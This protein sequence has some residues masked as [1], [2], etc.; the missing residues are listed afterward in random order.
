MNSPT[1]NPPPSNT[2][3]SSNLSLGELEMEQ[4]EPARPWRPL[5]IPAII[6]I[7]GLAIC[8]AL[9]A[10]YGRSKPDASGIVLRE[11]VYPVQVNAADSQS[12]P[13]M[14]A[15]QA[16]Q[17]ETI[18]LV[19]ARVTN[20]SRKPLTI[21]DMVADVKLDG[22]NNQSSAA[23]P[24]DIDRLFQ[25]FPDLAGNRTQLLA[26]HQVI[27]PGQSVQGLMVFNYA[28]SAQQWSQRKTPHLV[29]SFQNA[30]SLTLPLQ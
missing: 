2:R 4:M 23:L 19:Q 27:A 21:F 29:I 13:G 9:F 20:I 7:I 28:W 12:D 22:N 10:H 16:E 6:V 26:R 24:E 5:V 1:S 11:T 15:T 3:S 8:W 25:R 30:R 17:D 14:A 18:V